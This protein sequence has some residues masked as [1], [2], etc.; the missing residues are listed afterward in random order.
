MGYPTGY[1]GVCEKPVPVRKF[2]WLAFIFGV[3]FLF[4]GAVIYVI[5]YFATGGRKCNICGSKV[6]KMTPEV[7]AALKIGA[8]PKAIPPPPQPQPGVPPSQFCANCGEPITGEF[9]SKCGAP[10]WQVE[11]EETEKR[12]AKE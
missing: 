8:S 4:I 12:Q 11:G 10:R 3:F 1:C 5:Y 7:V 9:C 2:S 6:S